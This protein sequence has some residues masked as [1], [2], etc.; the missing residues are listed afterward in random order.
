M[1]DDIN[2][3]TGL[4]RRLQP[5][6]WVVLTL[7][8]VMLWGNVSVMNVVSGAV[9]AAL[10]LLLFP[11]PPVRYGIRIRPWATFVL[12]TRFFADMVVA[13]IEVAYK[14]CAPWE[15]PQG[16]L[17]RVI[18][19]SDNDLLNTMTAQMTTLVP[20]SIVIDIE[21]DGAGRTMLVH[22]F[23]VRSSAQV[24]AFLRRVQAQED[25]VIKALSARPFRPRD[26]RDQPGGGSRA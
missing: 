26:E 12:F 6:T 9:V 5:V 10:V 1:T 11:L 7:V 4:A 20:G 22:I 15:H 16:R 19:R 8:W 14:A 25:R 2:T 21:T 18:L 3:R 23:D 24:E 13:S 17:A